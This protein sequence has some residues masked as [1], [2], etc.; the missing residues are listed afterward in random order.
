MAKTRAFITLKHHLTFIRVLVIIFYFNF[1]ILGFIFGNCFF[2]VR[3]DCIIIQ[4][5]LQKL[6]LITFNKVCNYFI[7]MFR[8][9]CLFS[10]F[11]LSIQWN[12][13]RLLFLLMISLVI[14]RLPRN[15]PISPYPHSYFLHFS[16]FRLKSFWTRDKNFPSNYK[17]KHFLFQIKRCIYNIIRM[18]HPKLKSF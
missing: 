10:V 3:G 18:F 16:N 15:L 6:F 13:L 8:K 17:V 2:L 7:V 4:I 9:W 14:C 5:F 1:I 12:I 11:S